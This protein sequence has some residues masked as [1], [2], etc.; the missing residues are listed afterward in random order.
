[1]FDKKEIVSERSNGSAKAETAG[2]QQIIVRPFA[3]SIKVQL[4]GEEFDIKP[5]SYHMSKIIRQFRH[6]HSKKISRERKNADAIMKRLDDVTKKLNVPERKK[7]KDQKETESV[8][9]LLD[10]VDEVHAQAWKIS[11]MGDSDMFRLVQLIVL[12]SKDKGWRR[13]H[14]SFPPDEILETAISYDKLY[15]DC[16]LAELQVLLDVYDQMNKPEIPRKNFYRLG[17][18]V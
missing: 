7:T 3:T 13:K 8:D 1:M 2:E 10:V 5:P 17:T 15:Y 18:L 14:E 11:D 4:A 12:D 16:D 6:E 9:A